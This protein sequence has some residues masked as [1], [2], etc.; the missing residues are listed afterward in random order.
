[1]D[2]AERLLFVG[3]L[4]GTIYRI[5]LF[6]AQSISEEGISQDP[7]SHVYQGHR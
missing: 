4:N 2:T 6:S 5:D 3:G 7:N 1:M